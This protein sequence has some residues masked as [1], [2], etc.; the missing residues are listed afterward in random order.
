MAIRVWRMNF[1]VSFF[2]MIVLGFKLIIRSLPKPLRRE[3][4]SY[5]LKICNE[6]LAYPPMSELG[7]SP[8]R[9]S[10]RGLGGWRTIGYGL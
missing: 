10:W 8:F 1:H 9:G 6:L 4:M 5:S 3:G 2:F 7:L